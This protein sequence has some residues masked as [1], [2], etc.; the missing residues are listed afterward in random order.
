MLLKKDQS[1]N[2][3]TIKSKYAALYSQVLM[4]IEDMVVITDKNGIVEYVNP[5]FEK[6]TG[7]TKEEAIG[8][9]SNLLRSGK[10]SEDQYKNLW[11]T[12]L[13]GKTYL[14][15]ITNKKKDNNLYYESK[16]ITPIKN[17]RGEIT[18]FISIGKDISARKEYEINFEHR[19]EDF[20]KLIENISDIIL[21]V[22]PEGTIKYCS[23]SVKEALGYT[24]DELSG[25]NI[26]SFIDYMDSE[27]FKKILDKYYLPDDK[28]V[29]VKINIVHKNRS[30][31]YYELKVKEL[32]K[33]RVIINGRDITERKVADD[34][35]IENNNVPKI[36]ETDKIS[37]LIGMLDKLNQEIEW[38]KELEAQMLYN[39]DR[40][41]LILDVSE[42]GIFDFDFVSGKI[43]YNNNYCEISGYTRSELENIKYKD[44]FKIIYPGDLWYFKRELLKHL[45]LETEYLQ[46]EFRITTKEKEAKWIL[47]VGKFTQ[48][49][50]YNVPT[51]FIGKVE[52]IGPRK[53]AEKERN[54]LFGIEKE[55]NK[56]KSN[57]ISIVSHE[58]RTPLTTILSSTDI[59]RTFSDEMTSE[60]KV[61]HFN[62]IEKSIDDL[63]KLL[64]GV[65][66][67]N[68]AHSHEQYVKTVTIEIIGF[69]KHI[70][71]EVS[72]SYEKSPQ[73]VFSC[74]VVHYSIQSDEIL[75]RQIIM[76]L[77]NNSIKYNRGQNEIKMSVEIGSNIMISVEDHGI[78]IK[79]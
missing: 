76:N 1:L 74:D 22:T 23:P 40:L 49:D 48:R 62:R 75:L 44:W 50:E 51:R 27:K 2:I 14:A 58:F 57:F 41:E 42:Q 56:I 36:I 59:L 3:D 31:H 52:D 30:H 15:E 61:K 77:L 72:K 46:I 55:L 70:I 16:T 24:L 71:E 7:Y 21:V 13:E 4:N 6:F 45:R 43:Y 63:T 26:F 47:F 60:E 37:D 17:S 68:K 69:C 28:E 25:E 54:R 11:N 29:I 19:W 34:Y 33:D 35:L 65:L 10:Q 66:T 79:T 39:Q 20:K 38:R 64:N 32:I 67:L 12:I 53:K 8:K 5:A 78:G 73:I 18:H 9:K